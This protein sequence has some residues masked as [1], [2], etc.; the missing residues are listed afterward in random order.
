MQHEPHCFMYDCKVCSKSDQERRGC[1][2]PVPV[3]HKIDCYCGGNASCSLCSGKEKIPLHRCIHAHAK[4]FHHD[5]IMRYYYHYKNSHQ[6]P[7]GGPLLNQ[8]IMLISVFNLISMI[9]SKKEA[10]KGK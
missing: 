7:D 6:F 4:M 8:P 3:A 10:P 5:Y 1:M 2:N 9:F